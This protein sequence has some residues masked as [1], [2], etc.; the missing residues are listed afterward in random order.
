M[1][2]VST[3]KRLSVSVVIPV[4]N[5]GAYLSDCLDSVLSQKLS[6][7]EVICVDDGSTDESPRILAEYAARDVRV[8]VLTQNNQ[9]AGVARNRGMAAAKGEYIA[10]LDADDAFLPGSL[11][12]LCDRAEKYGLDF[13]KGGFQYLD[14]WGG[15]SY[16]TLYSGNSGV[17]ALR[18]RQVLSFEKLPARLLHVPDV[19]WNGL[20]RRSFLERN[21]IRFNS[22]RCV[23]DHS[24][25]IHCLLKADRMMVT[26]RAVT[27]YRVE[28]EGSLVGGKAYHFENQLASY[29]IVKELCLR[30]RPEH[31]QMVMEQEL[32][33]VFTWYHRLRQR[34]EAAK[35]L[36]EQLTEFLRELDESDVGE[37]FLREF[38]FREDYYRMRYGKEAPGRPS[39]VRRCL[40]CWREHGWRYTM[41]RLFRLG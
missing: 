28:Q 10:F 8:T 26:P 9:Y 38:P 12:F 21:G 32:N 13:I 2:T 6:S 16:T 30:E 20:Y 5:A 25:Y 33:G 22:L 23:N 40:R 15:R 3:E 35:R 11:Q 39:A 31:L 24:F 34:Q 29:R 27:C 18:S 1:E 17:G 19:P 7:M 41:Q 14:A 37:E 4:Y 36:E